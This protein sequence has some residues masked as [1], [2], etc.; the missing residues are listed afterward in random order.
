MSKNAVSV[1]VSFALIG[2][3]FAVDAMYPKSNDGST[4]LQ[5]D[6]PPVRE[7]PAF[8]YCGQVERIDQ[9]SFAL[10]RTSKDTVTQQVI[11]VYF[12][13]ASEK[14]LHGNDLQK[15]HLGA[16]Y[17]MRLRPEKDGTYHVGRIF[18]GEDCQ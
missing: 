17:S 7:P 16:K 18:N 13:D 4:P 9:G 12:S 3:A 15:I 1:C 8:I 5:A 6:T 11:R 10:V 14:I 2:G